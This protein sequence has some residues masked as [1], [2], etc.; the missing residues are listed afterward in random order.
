[1]TSLTGAS[2][3]DFASILRSLGYRMER[4]PKP[5]EP[6]PAP[7]IEAAT[8]SP[9]PESADEPNVGQADD[10]AAI[11]A[12]EPAD[13]E[14]SEGIEEVA[15]VADLAPEAETAAPSPEVEPAK[16][17]VGSAEKISACEPEMVDV[18]RPGRAGRP[19]RRRHRPRSREADKDVKHAPTRTDETV[20]AAGAEANAAAPPSPETGATAI[21][22]KEGH[23]EA[24]REGRH[25]RHRRRHAGEHRSERPS[26]DR[27][28][29]P[30]KRFERREKA[31]DPNSPFAKLAALKAQLEAE[32]KERN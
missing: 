25:F 10:S 30:V 9:P 13:G 4:R 21:S 15:A 27:D 29:P 1:M 26:R 17:A 23:K 24:H 14:K 11:P 18:W 32:A 22:A 16:A 19:E 7:A 31:P 20:A 3:E 12:L 6:D 2:G 28:R 5:K 8:V